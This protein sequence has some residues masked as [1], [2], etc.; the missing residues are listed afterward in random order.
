L[1]DTV[2]SKRDLGTAFLLDERKMVAAR[3]RELAIGL[4]A[5][6]HSQSTSSKK[7]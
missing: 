4:P 6:N 1:T 7:Q 3:K 5:T 2:R